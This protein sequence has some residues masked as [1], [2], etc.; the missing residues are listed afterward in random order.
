MNTQMIE[1]KLFKLPTDH[2]EFA[3]LLFHTDF[4]DLK[5]IP[6]IEETDAA[7]KDGHITVLYALCLRGAMNTERLDLKL[8]KNLRTALSL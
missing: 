4:S 6:T 3:Q 8:S 1:Q 5:S 2:P 7:K